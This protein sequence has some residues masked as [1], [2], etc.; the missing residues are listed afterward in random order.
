MNFASENNRTKLDHVKAFWAKENIMKLD[1]AQPFW[2][3]KKNIILLERGE[4]K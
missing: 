1:Q 3:K 4:W 2:A